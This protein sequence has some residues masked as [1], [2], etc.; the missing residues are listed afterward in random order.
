MEFSV[1]IPLYNEEES[2]PRLNERLLAACDKITSGYEVIYVDDGSTDTSSDVLKRLS[3]SF[4]QIKFLTF[5]ENRGQSAGLY[6][7]FRAS[8]GTWIITLD[9]DLQNPPEEILRLWESREGFDFITG[10]REK[11]M[12]SIMRKVSSQVARIFRKV[13]LNDTTKDVGCSL[14]VFHRKVVDGLP[15]FRNF[16]RFFTFLVRQ[17]GYRVKEI[18]LQHHERTYG[19]SKYTTLTRAKEGIFD[20]FGVFW[21]KRRLIRYELKDRQ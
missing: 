21:L 7:G 14:R 2:L 11:R 16:H 17:A 19:H 3:S 18:P 6:A 15:Y 1:V 8:S 5:T 12:D 13:T 10:I 20:L 4:P 9:A